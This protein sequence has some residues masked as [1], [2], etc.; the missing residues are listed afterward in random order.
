MARREYCIAALVAMLGC[1]FWVA[2]AAEQYRESQQ[3]EPDWSHVPYQFG[4]WKGADASFDPVYGPDPADTILLRSYTTEETTPSV[5][6]YV[7]FYRNLSTILDVHTPEL[8][9]PAQGWAVSSAGSASV[10]AFRGTKIPAK[11]I[12]VDK[13]GTKRLVMWWYNAGGKPFQTRIRYV[14]AMLMMSTLTGRTDGSMVRLETT[15]EKGGEALAAERLI[16]FRDSFLPELE[17]A[18]PR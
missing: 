15:F 12:T 6:V 7:G 5:I 3:Q 13:D 8:C 11:E 17:K 16:S 9:Y 18:L 2:R 4:A 1:T 14:Y 10:G